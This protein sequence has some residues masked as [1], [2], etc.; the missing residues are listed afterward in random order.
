MIIS[1]NGQSIG[2]S[3][4]STPFPFLN[5]SPRTDV[6]TTLYIPGTRKGSLTESQRKELLDFSNPGHLKLS[7]LSNGIN[8]GDGSVFQTAEFAANQFP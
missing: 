6:P 1:E 5:P 8:I 7:V 2:N 4:D 3:P